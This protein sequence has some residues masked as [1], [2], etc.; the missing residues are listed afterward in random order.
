L[1]Q[2]TSNK[3]RAVTIHPP[4]RLVGEPKKKKGRKKDTRNSGKLAIRPDHPRRRIKIKL[5]MVGGLRCVVIHVKCDQN[6]LRGYGAVVGRKWPFPITLASGLYNSLYY[7]TSRDYF[8]LIK[9]VNP[10]SH[11]RMTFKPRER[12]R[13]CIP[14][15]ITK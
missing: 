15:R 5:C 14:V 8:A 9:P 10:G 4:P 2:N 11:G 13:D 3:R 7:R 1:P 6:R 12:E